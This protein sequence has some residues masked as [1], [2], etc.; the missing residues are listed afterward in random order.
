MKFKKPKNGHFNAYCFMCKH[1]EYERSVGCAHLGKCY[2][3]H[4][5]VYE[6]DAYDPPCGL[7]KNKEG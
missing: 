7:F 6:A 5:E 3:V 1:Y 2:G 4:G